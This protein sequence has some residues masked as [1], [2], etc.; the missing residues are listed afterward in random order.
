MN[1]QDRLNIYKNDIK[2]KL[3]NKES[4]ASIARYY[5]V[6][7]SS[8][9]KLLKD[10]NFIISKSIKSIQLYKNKIKKMILDGKSYRNIGKKLNLLEGSIRHFCIRN[11][12]KSSHK[13]NFDINHLAKDHVEEILKLYDS[14]DRIAEIQRKTKLNYHSI[15]KIILKNNRKL[16]D[17][18]TYFVNDKFF[19]VIDSEEKAYIAGWMWSDGNTRYNGTMRITLQARDKYILDWIKNTLQYDGS[20]KFKKRK[21]E[22]HQDIYTLSIV[23]KRLT[24]KLIEKGCVPAKSLILKCPDYNTIPENLFPH[25]TRGYFEGDGSISKNRGH[26]HIVGSYDF[27]HEIINKIPCNI[28]GTYRAKKDCSKD[29]R[30]SCWKLIISKK[31]EARKFLEYIYPQSGC[32][33]RLERKYE[34]Y[35]NLYL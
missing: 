28:T 29:I 15:R 4:I 5:N 9:Y 17:F 7:S 12:L 24:N 32:C 35:K 27:I 2:N 26:I 6:H 10:W 13:C 33:M 31:E 3:D 30:K 21:K 1:I 16:N 23:R 22:H 34:I 14:G 11:N 8:L 18:T 25:F 20:I 19:D